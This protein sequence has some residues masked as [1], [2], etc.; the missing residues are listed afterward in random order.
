M[1][2]IKKKRQKMAK[3]YRHLFGLDWAHSHRCA[4]RGGV[5]LWEPEDAKALQSLKLVEDVVYFDE[6]HEEYYRKTTFV[7]RQGTLVTFHD[8]SY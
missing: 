3:E 7:S 5:H 6:Q 4:H 8:S 2:T 1:T